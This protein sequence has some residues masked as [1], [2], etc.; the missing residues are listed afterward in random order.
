MDVTVLHLHAL[1]L[2]HLEDEFGRRV[3]EELGKQGV[4]FVGEVTTEGMVTGAEQRVTHVVTSA[5]SFEADLVIVAI[6]VEPCC[7]LARGAGIRLGSYGG[8]RTTTT[9]QTNV[10][11]VFA[12]GDCCEVRNIVNNRFMY[13]PLATVAS[14]AGRVAGA[15]AAGS[16]SLFPGVIRAMVLRVFG[17][18]V[19]HVGLSAAEAAASGF[20]PVAETTTAWSKAPGMPGCGRIMIRLIADRRSGRLL[21]ANIMGEQGAALRAQTLALAIQ[22]R[23]SPD[24]LQRTDLPYAPPFAPLWDPLLVAAGAASRKLRSG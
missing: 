17:L 13:V 7:E 11:D 8:I 20:D 21:G 3:Q 22:Q 19:A 12:A 5:G 14:R 10:D 6:G 16:R 4:A 1:P 24:D 18:E 2:N 15:N 23:I 9:Q